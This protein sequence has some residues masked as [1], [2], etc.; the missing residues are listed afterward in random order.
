MPL[1]PAM[2]E[3]ITYNEMVS[4]IY[5]GQAIERLQLNINGNTIYTI[6]D[7]SLALGSHDE[8]TEKKIRGKLRKEDLKGKD[9]GL[10]GRYEFTYLQAVSV[11]RF[12][13]PLLL[14]DS[15]PIKEAETRNNPD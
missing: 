3:N 9:F 4:A 14:H 5:A 13:A 8:K 15:D 2:K 12:L 7:I 10:R 11:I 1:I 6:K